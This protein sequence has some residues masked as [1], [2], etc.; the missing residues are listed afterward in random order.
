VAKRSLLIQTLALDSW[1]PLSLVIS[2]ISHILLMY[3]AH[4]PSRQLE[5]L[6]RSSLIT[7]LRHTRTVSPPPADLSPPLNQ[8][9]PK[10]PNSSYQPSITRKVNSNI[11]S[12]QV[13]RS[14]S[15]I[16]LKELIFGSSMR[17]P[18]GVSPI[19]ADESIFTSRERLEVLAKSLI[20]RLHCLSSL[21]SSGWWLRTGHR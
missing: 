16:L 20:P 5:N 8:L 15:I 21:P 6:Y 14:D 1:T 11:L 19:K 2:L 4:T 12:R 9:L 13:V 18:T 3:S 7:R 17:H 10:S